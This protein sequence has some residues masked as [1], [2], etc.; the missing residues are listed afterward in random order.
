MQ[1][2]KQKGDEWLENAI[3]VDRFLVIHRPRSFD[4]NVGKMFFDEMLS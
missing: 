4:K 3:D 2:G 1:H